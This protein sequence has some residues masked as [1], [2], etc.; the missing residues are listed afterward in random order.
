MGTISKVTVLPAMVSV[1]FLPP[2]S[3]GFGAAVGASAACSGITSR[4]RITMQTRYIKAISKWGRFSI[5]RAGLIVAIGLL[6]CG[7]CSAGTKPAATTRATLL[8]QQYV[9]LLMG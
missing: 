8:R 6:L 7:G 2:G 5:P 3:A 9:Q 1:N 4:V